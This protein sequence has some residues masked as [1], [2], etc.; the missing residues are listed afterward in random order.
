[1]G[2]LLIT[3]TVIVEGVFAAMCWSYHRQLANPDATPFF[4]SF[5]ASTAWQLYGMG[6]IPFLF[7]GIYVVFFRRQI[8]TDRTS[9]EFPHLSKSSD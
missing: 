8:V 2:G 5:P 7:V 3:T 9:A 4:G 6:S 1:M